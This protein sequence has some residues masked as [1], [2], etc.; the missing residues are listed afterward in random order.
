MKMDN[1]LKV[2]REI[3]RIKDSLSELIKLPEILY[4]NIKSNS[5]RISDHRF[6]FNYFDKPEI[7]FRK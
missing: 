3:Y 6:C 2:N 7:I 4:E 1:L 5:F